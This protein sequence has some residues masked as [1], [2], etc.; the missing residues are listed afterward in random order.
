MDGVA[1]S[2]MGVT[3]VGVSLRARSRACIRM[4]FQPLHPYEVP[5]RRPRHVAHVLGG[6]SAIERGRWAGGRLADVPASLRAMI[7]TPLSERMARPVAPAGRGEHLGRIE[8]RAGGGRRSGAARDRHVDVTILQIELALPQAA[9]YS[10]RA[11]RR[12]RIRGLPRGN[13]VSASRRRV[14][15]GPCGRSRS[16]GTWK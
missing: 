10:S 14:L 9:R 13:L 1:E 4:P 11:R 15:L 3:P 2:C 5:A 6:E 8:Q 12:I 16:P 7:A